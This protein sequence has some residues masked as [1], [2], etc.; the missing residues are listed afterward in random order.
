[1]TRDRTP[2][3][4]HRELGLFVKREDLCNPGGPGFS[5]SRGVFAHVK[6]QRA[7]TIAVLDT[8]HS[9]GGWAVAQACSVLGKRC[10]VF[11]PVRKA[12]GDAP[13]RPLQLAAARLGAELI[14]LPAAR[15]AIL[16]H[17]VRRII[18]NST[19]LMPNALKLQESVAE[20]AAEVRRTK[21]PPKLG[22]VIV[23][24][25]SGTIAA[26]VI[27]GLRL[28]KRWDGRIVVHMGYR[29]PERAVRSYIEKMGFLFGSLGDVEFIDEGYS[30]ADKA[31]PG[32][33]PSFPCD[34]YYDLKALR[35]WSSLED[36]SGYGVAMLWNIG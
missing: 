33:V 26:G 12:E 3:E 28:E 16:Y 27:R 29:R 17:R 36:R 15:S 19:Y 18:G 5:K 4:F 1:M 31:K 2:L 11:Y 20:T 13:A 23:S 34:V 35:W 32:P 9:R 24:A 10:R 14:A 8:A 21:L 6:A 25:S 7:D 30:Y 22:T